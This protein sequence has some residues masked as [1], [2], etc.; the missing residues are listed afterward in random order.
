MSKKILLAL[1]VAIFVPGLALAA[2]EVT[3]E[4]DTGIGT[5][6]DAGVITAPTA[7]P[8]A[9]TYSATQNV[10][11][12]AAGSSG[13]CYST[14]ANPV[15]AYSGTACTAGTLYAG[16]IAV[17]QTATLRGISCYP[18]GY[19]SAVAAFAYTIAGGGGG[20]GGGGSPPPPQISNIQVT[21][22][23][24]TAIITWTT[25][26]NATSRVNYGLTSQYGET[27]S[28]GTLVTSHSITLTG[29]TPS[30]TYHYQTQSADSTG[31]TG[32]YSDK[33]FT[34]TAGAVTEVVGTGTVTQTT[35][36]LITA[37]STEGSIA[38]A[39]FPASAVSADTSVSITPVGKAEALVGTPPAGSFMVGGYVY[40]LSATVA[41]VAVTT[42]AQPVTLTFTYTNAQISGLDESTLKIYRWDATASQWVVLPST[43][44]A[45]TNTVTA[46]T[47][48]FSYFV[49]MGEQL[50]VPVEEEEEE[51]KP[52]S[53]M[54]IAELQAKITQILALI[55]QLQAQIAGLRGEAVIVGVPAGYKFTAT[56]KFGQ[57]ADDVK[58]LQIVLNSDSATRVA[59]S[60]VG[61]PGHETNYFGSLTN[62]AVIKFQEKY[63]DEVLAPWKFAKGTGIVGPTTRDKL[64][65]LLGW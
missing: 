23:S 57:V 45:A 8:A 7:N 44:D 3:G 14:G 20:G 43:V 30:T 55:T 56:L 61:S 46:T 6:F 34:T 31:S 26:K 9:G 59:E 48:E 21:V 19:N 36:G 1:I 38:R 58:Y 54:T 28:S 42:F 29:L 17:T 18:N 22:T 11:L 63:Y 41:G 40:T 65:K 60:G 24:S 39:D 12:T 5:G 33:T 53:E 10:V 13:I 2:S 62:A 16:A 51:E 47:T 25:N 50:V 4:L 35:G 64:N 49:L 37:T 15:C 27:V 32:S 52:I